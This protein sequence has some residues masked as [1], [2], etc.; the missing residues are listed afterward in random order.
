MLMITSRVKSV[1]AKLVRSITTTGGHLH[2]HGS[3]QMPPYCGHEDPHLI[4]CAS[5]NDAL[6]KCYRPRFPAL[7]FKAFGLVGPMNLA[8]T[9]LFAFIVAH[10]QGQNSNDPFVIKLTLENNGVLCL[11]YFSFSFFFLLVWHLYFSSLLC[12]KL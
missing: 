8:L 4:L 6:V 11:S 9:C 1:C 3:P 7:S 2:M 12:F 10:F 5:K